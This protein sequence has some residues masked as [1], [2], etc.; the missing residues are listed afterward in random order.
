MFGFWFH[1]CDQ[2]KNVDQ[3]VT[4]ILGENPI[5]L[6][7][8]VQRTWEGGSHYERSPEKFSNAWAREKLGAKAPKMHG[9][10]VLGCLGYVP[11]D[12]FLVGYLMGKLN[13]LIHFAYYVRSV[14][15]K[16]DFMEFNFRF[17]AGQFL[18]L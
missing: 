8:W 9:N 7:V 6:M 1:A 5:G 3:Y 4:E 13:I 12:E 2:T 18:K 11:G 10:K 16:Q 17:F 15:T 14:I